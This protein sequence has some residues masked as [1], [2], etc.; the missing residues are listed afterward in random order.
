MNGLYVLANILFISLISYR[1]RKQQTV[2]FL[3]V[4]FW[5]ALVFKLICGLLVGYLYQHYLL[6]GD[7]FVYQQQAEILSRYAS[8]DPSNYLSFL[9]TGEY[10]SVYLYDVMKYREYSNS[11]FMVLVL[12]FLNFETGYNY[13]L[14]AVYFSLFSFYGCWQLTVTITKVFP[15]TKVAAALAFLF[16]PSVV[17][18]SSGVLKES[19]LV[20]SSTLLLAVVLQFVYQPGNQKVVLRSI[21]LLVAAFFCFKIRFYFAVAYF[22]LLAGFALVELAARRWH[23]PRQ[24]KLYF[25]LVALLVLGIGASFLHEAINLD[26][27]FRELINSYQTSKLATTR[28]AFIDLPHLQPTFASLIQ[29]APKAIGSAIFRPFLG[30]INSVEYWLAGFENLLVLLLAVISLLSFWKHKSNLPITL[31]VSLLIYILLLAGLI[32]FSTANLGSVS[33]YKVAFMPFLLY[34]LLQTGANQKILTRLENWVNDLLS[35]KAK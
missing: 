20:G 4:I 13:Y 16:F 10:Q 35:N 29:Y 33:R 30:E 9:L 6:G 21:A 23:L 25:Y 1:G 2:P 15:A 7:T 31:V 8:Q 12:H 5:P 32:G 27:F 24:K 34:L 3:K 17:F 19:I 26:Y 22:P 18:W 14:N 11:F 28:K